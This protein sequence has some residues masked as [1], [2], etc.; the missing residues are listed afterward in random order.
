MAAVGLLTACGRTD[1]PAAGS[2]GAWSFTD[3]RDRKVSLGQRPTRIV[4]QVSAAA[5]LW[6]LG[7]H[8][9]G[10]FGPQKLK[11]GSNDPQV[12]VVDLSKVGSVGAE[13]GEFSMEKL[14]ALRPDLL[15][16]GMY[17]PPD[18]WYVTDDVKTKV[19][20]LVPTLGISQRSRNVLQVIERFNELGKSLGAQQSVI[21]AAKAD[22]DKASD[23]LRQA[24]AAKPGL[25]VLAVSAKA[26]N[27]YVGMPSDQPDLSYY[28]TLGMDVGGA[29]G[30]GVTYFEA[31][32]W[33][34]TTKYP[35]DL[36][37]YDDRTQ[38]GGLAELRTHPT[39]NSLPAVQAGQVAP[40]RSETPFSYA[41]F[42]PVLRELAAAVGK[43]RKL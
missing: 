19:E 25:R 11:D 39:W 43:A 1:S 41:R 32:S 17:K 13:Y 2:G 37:L 10:V 33:E 27:F 14:A 35:A 18:L 7:V 28:K 30:D 6:D 8:P 42:A 20:A 3:D 34:N 15:V 40:W 36:V 23:E 5:A 22:F 31:L 4:A 24:L 21:D 12:G 26:E 38:A 9:V 29:T 16:S